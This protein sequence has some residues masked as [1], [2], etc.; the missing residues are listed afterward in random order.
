MNFKHIV[1]AI[2][3]T[4][5]IFA[6]LLSLSY[7]YGWFGWSEYKTQWENDNNGFV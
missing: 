6:G 4:L 2:I 1:Y 3:L 5:I 7:T